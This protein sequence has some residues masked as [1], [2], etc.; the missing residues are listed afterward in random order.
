MHATGNMR[1]LF[2]VD[3]VDL[4]DGPVCM[5]VWNFDNI[6][7]L[8]LCTYFKREQY[9]IQANVRKQNFFLQKN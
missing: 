7:W 6:L 9:I 4:I 8:Q 5:Y 3:I 2:L 1:D